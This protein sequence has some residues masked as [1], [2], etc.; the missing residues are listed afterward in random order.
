[1]PKNFPSYSA[2][3]TSGSIIA[4][5]LQVITWHALNWRPSLNQAFYKNSYFRSYFHL[6]L[7]HI[8]LSRSCRSASIWCVHFVLNYPLPSQLFLYH[9]L[10]SKFESDDKLEAHEAHILLLLF[11]WYLLSPKS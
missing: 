2:S 1:M 10:V 11:I 3:S 8:T 5:L 7:Q 4:A 9:S 6:Q